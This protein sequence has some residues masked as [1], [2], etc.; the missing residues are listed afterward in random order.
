MSKRKLLNDNDDDGEVEFVFDDD[1]NKLDTEDDISL[2]CDN[3]KK[4]DKKKIKKIKQ[5]T[6][7][8][9]HQKITTNFNE[10]PNE[11]I[12]IILNFISNKIDGFHF[13]LVNKLIFNTFYGN[14]T[15]FFPM[16]FENSLNSYCNYFNYELDDFNYKKKIR[17]IS[18]YNDNI[19]EELNTLIKLIKKKK[20]RFTLQNLL[21][22]QRQTWKNWLLDSNQKKSIRKTL[23]HLFSTIEYLKFKETHF[24]Y[25]H[26][27]TVKFTILNKNSG[28]QPHQFEFFLY[29]DENT[30]SFT[31]FYNGAAIGEGEGASVNFDK[32]DIRK[33]RKS[34]GLEE[35]S[36][37]TLL[38]FL[39]I[40][41]PIDLYYLTFE[42]YE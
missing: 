27:T 22:K 36:K 39:R 12:Q 16:D 31:Y 33:L 20:K 40:I 26:E 6:V 23:N 25:R 3:E 30:N 28:Q 1:D 10:L 8:K 5:M 11:V 7:P 41:I 9:I 21:Q 18:D 14:H 13:I 35:L 24:E 19:I 4:E 2:T 17:D 38:E 29:N 37:T 15:L 34:L 32:A 42:M